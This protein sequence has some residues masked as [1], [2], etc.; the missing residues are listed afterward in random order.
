[1]IITLENC[2]VNINRT[3]TP[4]LVDNAHF[5]LRIL[6]KTTNF[7]GLLAVNSEY[8]RAIPSLRAYFPFAFI[9][10]PTRNGNQ[11]F[12]IKHGTI[13]TKDIMTVRHIANRLDVSLFESICA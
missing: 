7:F 4:N 9:G 2:K 10:R 3:V 12:T 8:R 11:R 6:C 1:M 13:S 5:S